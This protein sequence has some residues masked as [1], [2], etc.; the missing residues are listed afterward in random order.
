MLGKSFRKDM[1]F[2]QSDLRNDGLVE[3]LG[4]DI[5][6]RQIIDLAENLSTYAQE[7]KLAIIDFV[8]SEQRR[9]GF[10]STMISQLIE[11]EDIKMISYEQITGQ[12]KSLFRKFFPRNILKEMA[13]HCSNQYEDFLAHH[14]LPDMI[15]I[16]PGIM[17]MS[18][19][20]NFEY[21]YNDSKSLENLAES[22]SDLATRYCNLHFL[23]DNKDML[24]KWY[25]SPTLNMRSF[26]DDTGIMESEIEKVSPF[27]ITRKYKAGETRL[28]V[29][30]IGYLAGLIQSQSMVLHN[31]FNSQALLCYRLQDIPDEYQVKLVENT[32]ENY[33]S[34]GIGFDVKSY[35]YDELLN[36]NFNLT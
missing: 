35:T 22:A 16:H 27:S 26:L 7:L 17:L 30:D 1:M 6:I 34:K 32:F 11:F 3:K 24:L 14:I 8:P 20:N 28:K 10:K 9:E 36:H 12:G 31:V 2:Y 29:T 18:D 5:V 19:D 21:K 23:S 4:G 15:G 25:F 33:L 13:E